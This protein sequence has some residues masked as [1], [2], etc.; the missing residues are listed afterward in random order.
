MTAGHTAQ[1]HTSVAVAAVVHWCVGWG[2]SQ[3]SAMGSGAAAT[4]ST[5][6]CMIRGFSPVVEDTNSEQH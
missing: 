6:T 3:D 4:Y 1:G 5:R 2:V